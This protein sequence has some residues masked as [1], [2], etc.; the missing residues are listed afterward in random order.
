MC[1]ELFAGLCRVQVIVARQNGDGRFEHRGEGADG[2]PAQQMNPAA[3]PMATRQG[4]NLMTDR[5]LI[6][7]AQ[8]CADEFKTSIL[9]KPAA[10]QRNDPPRHLQ[11]VR[12][13]I[14]GQ[15]EFVTRHHRDQGD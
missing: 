10:V 13:A 1:Q 14:P 7:C 5:R 15:R 8:T 2:M 9:R 6:F 12:A 4:L 3:Q 11:A